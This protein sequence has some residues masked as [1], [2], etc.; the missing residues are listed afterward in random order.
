M[1]IADVI[2]ERAADDPKFR[3]KVAETIDLGGLKESQG[4]VALEEHFKRGSE[5]Y[6]RSLTKRLLAGED[7]S[8]REIDY[9]RGALDIAKAIF[10]YPEVALDNLERTARRAWAARVEQEVSDLFVDASPYINKEVA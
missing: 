4:W 1:N 6:E 2:A 5:S 3:D 7:V 9:Y 10:K 8:Q